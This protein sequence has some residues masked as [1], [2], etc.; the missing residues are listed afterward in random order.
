[1]TIL[2]AANH[3]S[4]VAIG[5]KPCGLVMALLFTI[6]VKREGETALTWLF[7]DADVARRARELAQEQGIYQTGGAE[8]VTDFDEFAAWVRREH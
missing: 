2:W 7:E 8:Y 5:R 4:T 6:T 1:M 3:G